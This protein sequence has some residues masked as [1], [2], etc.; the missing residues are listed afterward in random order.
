MEPTEGEI[1]HRP[2]AINIS[3]KDPARKVLKPGSSLGGKVA[4]GVLGGAAIFGGAALTENL[5][6]GSEAN[7]SAYE[8]KDRN[9]NSV[10]EASGQAGGNVNDSS[11]VKE[12]L[13][14]SQEKFQEGQTLF[15]TVFHDLDS[16]QK[17][18]AR[19]WVE[20]FKVKIA[21]KPG[22]EKEHRKIPLEYKEI[23]KET[24]KAYG[25][26]EAMLYG[27]I[28][29]E[30]GGGSNVTNNI[31]GA[32]G[33]AQFLPDTARQYG[34][35]VNEKQDQRA[36]PVL[37]IDAAGRYL[38][39]HKTL[40]G[41]DVGLTMWSYHAGAGNVYNALQVYFK[42]K[43]REDIGS[44]SEA[45]GKNDAVARVRVESKA[46]ELMKQDKLDIFKLFSNPA[47][48]VEVEKLDDF[49]SSYV[50]QI[51]AIM[52]L[53]NEKKDRVVDLGGGLKI[54]VQKNAFPSR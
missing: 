1:V 4:A 35:I 13:V 37:S 27:I 24:A 42:D 39:D 50:P 2:N 36:D 38:R 5:Y 26:S 19:K 17:E 18:E 11:K 33:V 43:F 49:T 45:I 46:K 20:E 6:G 52:Q 30:N 41:G 53:E 15:D 3:P 28:A 16:K 10:D 22:Y 32:R 25:I 40:F 7:A 54:A 14:K 9:T 51:I 23:I 12:Q 44:Y 8:Q 29:I 21:A 47:V 31:S 48:K 34:L